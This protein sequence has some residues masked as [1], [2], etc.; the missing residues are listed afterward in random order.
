MDV[1][2]KNRLRVEN[3]IGTIIDVHRHIGSEWESCQGF[4]LQCE[5][6]KGMVEELDMTQVSEKDILMLEKATNDLLNE[7]KS[8]F[9]AGKPGSIYEGLD[10]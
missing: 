8:I 4:E 10:D 5:R 3:C 9:E 6:L 2:K 7:F 1:E